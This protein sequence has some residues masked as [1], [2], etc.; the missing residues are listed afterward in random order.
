MSLNQT[1][2]DFTATFLKHKCD[3]SYLHQYQPKV[4]C[5]GGFHLW[6]PQ[7]FWDFWPHP[8]FAIPVL[9]VR[10]IGQFLDPLPPFGADIINESLLKSLLTVLYFSETIHYRSSYTETEEWRSN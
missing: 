2:L 6:R 8:S 3:L 4:T 7:D 5:L 1:F 10:K 9:F